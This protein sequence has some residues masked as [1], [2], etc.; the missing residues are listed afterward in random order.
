[1]NK[2]LQ[3]LLLSLLTPGLGYLQNGDKKNFY[4][5]IS[6]FFGVIM[7]GVVFR[8][9][10][11]FKGLSFVIVALLLIYFFTTVHSTIKAKTSNSKTD[12]AGLLKPFFTI[13]FILVTGLSFANRRTIMG[14]DIMS[15]SVP[16]MQPAVS[17]GD[18]FLINT[19]AYNNGKP[20]RNDIVA[21]SFD[22]QSGL[23]L[24][25]IIAIENDRIKIINGVVFLDDQPQT[26]QYV[27]S[28][29][30]TRPESK[31]MRQIIV[32]KGHYFV[33][34]D[35]RDASFGDSKFSG[36]ITI[37]NIQGKITDIIS[38]RDKSKIGI[39]VK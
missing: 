33:M 23:F 10:T 32:P 38:S 7:F 26:E 18:K 16:V 36:T 3:T 14:F 15:M 30:V 31:N 37:T 39:T 9:F 20:K 1:M 2:R 25:R 8:L 6:F 34:G 24:N 11:S 29:N 4:R 19:W 12:I 17:Q 21:H 5:T 35:N 22:G 28:S 27:L 13:F